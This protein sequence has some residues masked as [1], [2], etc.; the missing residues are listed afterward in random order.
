MHLLIFMLYQGE[1]LGVSKDTKI[2]K[3]SELLTFYEKIDSTSKAKDK[4]GSP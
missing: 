1:S 3:T 2:I 4:F